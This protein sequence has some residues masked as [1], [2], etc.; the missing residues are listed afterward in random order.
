M[1]AY[2]TVR[3]EVELSMILLRFSPRYVGDT[4]DDDIPSTFP[5]LDKDGVIK[6]D[7]HIDSGRILN[8]PKGKS[9]NIYCKVCDRGTYHL[10]SE[11]R[12]V[13]SIE[14]DYVPNGIIPGDYSDYIKMEIDESGKVLNWP[15]NPCVSE[16][17]E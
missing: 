2:I 13:A 1:K 17:F 11:G 10:V 3:K 8:W 9:F 7:I 6:M 5:L 14:D 12:I 15:K 4:E 16:F